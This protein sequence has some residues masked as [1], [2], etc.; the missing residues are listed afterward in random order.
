MP[1][2]RE[3][4]ALPDAQEVRYACVLYSKEVCVMHYPEEEK[5]LHRQTTLTMSPPAVVSAPAWPPPPRPR[6]PQGPPVW[7]KALVI[8]LAALL[9]LGGLGLLIYSTTDQYNLTLNAPRIH[10]TAAARAAVQATA[11]AARLAR[12]TAVPLA[13]ANAQVYATQTAQAGPDATATAL[14]AQSTE[15][16]QSMVALL[17][18]V[19]EGTPTLDDPLS[20]NSQGNVWDVGYA[21]NNNTGCNF[22]NGSYQ[23]LEALPGR[24]QP[25]FADAMKVTNFAYQ[26][27]LTFNSNCS[28]GLIL[29][30]DKNSGHL[31]LF[32]I[33]TNG[34]YQFEV[35]NGSQYYT[36]ASGTSPAILG[37]GQPDTLVAV[38]DQ[39]VFDLFVNQ[40]FL[41]EAIDGQLS[42]GQIG[43]AVENTGVP[44][45]ASFSEAKVWKI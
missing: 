29:R 13:T 9:V 21:D 23:V 19:T 11:T 6:P 17:N 4:V 10:A 40:A 35:Y 12:V 14:N 18:R 34:S 38:A 43:V 42:A 30:G 26:V 16:S 32:T 45:S 39:G 8:T 28:A 44:A 1:D 27:S 7:L 3:S 33:N 41:T 25:C 37:A 31:Y 22:V 15:T 36:L 20:S 24:F 5:L 2:E